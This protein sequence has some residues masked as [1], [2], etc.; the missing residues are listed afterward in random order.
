MSLKLRQQ[1]AKAE[2]KKNKI[3]LLSVIGLYVLACMI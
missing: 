2:K 1:E 3:I